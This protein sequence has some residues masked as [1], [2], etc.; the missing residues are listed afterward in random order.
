MVSAAFFLTILPTSAKWLYPGK[1][2]Q[3]QEHDEQC[4][5][6]NWWRLTHQ[7]FGVSEQLLFAIP[8][9]GQRNVIVAAKLKAEGV[10]AGVPDLFLAVPNRNFSGLFIEMKKRKGGRVSEAQ[11]AMMAALV[12]EGYAV[13]VCHGWSEAQTTITEY[14][15]SRD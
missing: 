10:R 6:I 2:M 4:T 5:L 11:S 1:T 14:L 13:R 12:D 7:Q 15:S 8:N 9:G 3:Q